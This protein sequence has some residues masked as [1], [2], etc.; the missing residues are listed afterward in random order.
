[1]ARPLLADP[2]WVLKAAADAADEINTCIACNQACLDHVFVHKTVACLVNP[3]AGHETELVLGRRVVPSDRGRRRGTGRAG[4]GGHARP[5]AATRST[6][7]EAGDEIGGQFDLAR[8]IPGKEE[9]AETI[10]YYTRMLEQARRRGAA[11]D[12]ARRSTSWPASTRSCSRPVSSPRMPD[13]PGI[14]HPKVLSYAEAITRQAGRQDGGGRRRG[15]HRLRRQRVPVTDESPTLD[16]EE[17]KAEWGVGRSAGGT[18]RADD[19]DPAPPAARGVPA[20]ADEGP[21]ASGL[22]KTTGWVH[23]AALKAK[24]VQQL[25]GV[26]YERIDDDGLH[27]SFGP[28]TDRAFSRSTT[29]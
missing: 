4:G 17:W 21:R 1:M 9:F 13:I 5:S 23:R 20:A 18:R 7:F 19:A 11:S 25:S 15:R 3:R 16:L 12:A 26:N 8:R 2:D 6:L 24:G 27:I 28:T 10:R 22:G 14:D 29:S